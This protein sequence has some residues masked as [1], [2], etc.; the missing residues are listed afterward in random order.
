MKRLK[1]LKKFLIFSITFFLLTFFSIKVVLAQSKP[2]ISFFYGQGCPHCAEA[3]IFLEEL[4][5]KYPHL[6][7]KEYEIY[8]H[9]DNQQLFLQ[10]CQ[11]YETEPLGVPM[12]FMGEKYFLGFN[13]G[14]IGQ[15]IE[16]YLQ[17]ILSNEGPIKVE[18]NN[19]LQNSSSVVDF[20]WAKIFS[21]AAADAV[22]PCALAVLS[23]MLIAIMTANPRQKKK[24]LLAG[25]AFTSS[26]F[27]MYL[28]YGLIIIKFFQLIQVL[29]NVRLIF[30]KI[31]AGAA[32]LLGLLNIRD[33]F[34]YR[35]GSFLTEMPMCL[36]P[37]VQKI[38]RGITSPRNAFI[39]GIFVT[40]FLLPCT[41]GPY[42]IA[43]GI[44]S[45]LEIL[46]TF[47]FLFVYNLI[48]I[49]PMLAIT[50]IIYIGLTRVKD[51]AGWKDK[52]IRYLHLIA[53][54]IIFFLG[55]AMLLGWI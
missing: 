1:K 11:R 32:I 43:G 39:I 42:L 28:I 55:I 4:Q 25:L 13:K 2:E 45:V 49:L 52:N 26:I 53:G 40:L 21:L 50:I 23:L 38:I 51:V 31:L 14:T 29:S 16:N 47:P 5:E 48:F 18:E 17:G 7:V 33:F 35:P 19:Q 36:R 22:N 20:T 46:K 6:E 54:L 24:V 41:A 3:K 12:F 15:E 27:V 37:R 9:P 34:C 10:F 30:Y 8:T 44:L